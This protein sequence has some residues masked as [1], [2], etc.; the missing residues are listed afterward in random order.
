MRVQQAEV[1]VG[2][3]RITA[4]DVTG[5]ELGAT[6]SDSGGHFTLVLNGHPPF[7]LHVLKLGWMPSSSGP[8]TASRADTLVL[9]MLVPL[10]P[11]V[12]AAV[13]I[14][15]EAIRSHN[16]RSLDEARQQGWKVYSPEL[17]ARHRD[18]ATSFTALMREVGVAGV[19]IDDRA[20]ADGR[21]CAR[22]VRS[23]RCL[24]YVLDGVPSG[25]YV[26]VNPREVYFFAVLSATE[27]AARFGDKAPWGAIAI[28][29]RMNGD[30]K[31]P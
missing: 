29:T 20:S 23:G 16:Y 14:R 27:S 24:S 18:D 11:A 12:I 25:S 19:Q 22:S 8:I 26:Y 13:E 6:T 7:I 10:D 17:V 5:A 15:G 9:D 30:E 28:Y 3:A 21:N 4:T 2:G 31:R 1:A